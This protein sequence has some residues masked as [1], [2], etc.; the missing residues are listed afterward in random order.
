MV[1]IKMVAATG[2]NFAVT[3]RASPQG[4]TFPF[5]DF[6]NVVCKDMQSSEPCACKDG[7]SL[8]IE[9]KSIQC[10]SVDHIAKSYIKTFGNTNS[11]LIIKKTFFF[12]FSIFLF[13][14][15]NNLLFY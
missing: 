2:E 14:S 3:R 5:L 6:Q 8:L 15:F 13:Y 10:R 4:D 12:N 9:A 7:G 11:K 1:T